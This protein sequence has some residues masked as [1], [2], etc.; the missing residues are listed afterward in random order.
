MIKLSYSELLEA[1]AHVFDVPDSKE[2]SL[3]ARLRH[4]RNIGLLAARPGKGQR[5]A[6]GFR[7]VARLALALDLTSLGHWPQDVLDMLTGNDRDI[8]KLFGMCLEGIDSGNRTLVITRT[9]G[10]FDDR[11]PRIELTAITRPKPDVEVHVDPSTRFS[12]FDFG[13]RV[14]RLVIWMHGHGERSDE[15]FSS[16]VKQLLRDVTEAKV[17]R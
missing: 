8:A 1:L 7:D 12:V 13:E 14:R 6:Y 11:K 3:V 17:A 5:I 9:G 15:S 2:G 16:F 10:P 4:F